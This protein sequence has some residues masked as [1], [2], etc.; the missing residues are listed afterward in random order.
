MPRRAPTYTPL[1]P[2]PRDLAPEVL[3]KQEGMTVKAAAEYLT[4][5]LRT[6]K[7]LVAD[8]T[9]PSVKIGR[10]R[11][12]FRAGVEAFLTELRRQQQRTR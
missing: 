2:R 10:R 5:C 8:G 11:V 9:L 7:A 6:T 1:I 3:A 12:V 4:L